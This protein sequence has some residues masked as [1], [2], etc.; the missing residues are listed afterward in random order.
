M[1]K[2]VAQK[3]VKSVVDFEKSVEEVAHEAD[4]IVEP[5]S[6][7]V[8]KRFPSLFTLLVTFGIAATFFGFEQLLASSAYLSEKPV[9]ILII[10]VAVLVG[11]G[12][13]YKK[14]G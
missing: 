4:T 13:L 6:K 2:K 10:G 12:K 7:S 8:F 3:I 5:V 11:T 1:P 9:L 14:L